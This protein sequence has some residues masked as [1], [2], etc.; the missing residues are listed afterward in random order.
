MGEIKCVQ[1]DEVVAKAA[2]PIEDLKLDLDAPA[3]IIF[4]PS[5][6]GKI[7]MIQFSHRVNSVPNLDMIPLLT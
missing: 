1:Y 3:V 4:G 5:I 7:D 6:A 2:A